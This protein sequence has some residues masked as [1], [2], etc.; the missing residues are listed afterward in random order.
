MTLSITTDYVDLDALPEEPPT[1]LVPGLI[2]AEQVTWL[3]GHPGQGK[4]T[5]ALF[6]AVEYM[7]DGGHVVW[8]DWEAGARPTMRRLLAVGATT[9]MLR[10]QFHYAPYP[11]MEASA[12]GFEPIADALER[13]PGAIVVFDSVSKALSHAGL[14]EHITS[15]ATRWTAELVMPVR[16]YGGS[17]VVIDHVIKGAT[18]STP[19]PTPYGRGDGSEVMFFIEVE[20]PFSREKIGR[21]RLTKHKDREGLLPDELRFTV[22][23]GR[24]GLP[25]R[26]ELRESD[27]EE[28]RDAR[29]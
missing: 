25:V 6:A 22:G 19:Y 27:D 18:R 10:D 7:K 15:D 24:G 12:A 29:R 8:L 3:A 20:E 2:I 26:E 16:E 13:W 5:L 17:A 21:L 11:R 1:V 23:D 9:E 14:A 28:A 4:T